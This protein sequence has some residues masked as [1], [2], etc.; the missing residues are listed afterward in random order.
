MD[1]ATFA[2]NFFMALQAKSSA[3]NSFATGGTIGYDP[4]KPTYAGQ[5]QGDNA[6]PD[7]FSKVPQ[8]LGS[9]FPQINQITGGQSLIP[10]AQRLAMST[11]TEKAFYS[12]FLQDEAGVNP[13]DVFDMSKRLAPQISNISTPRFTN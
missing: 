5:G 12:G 9:S 4:S 2:A 11:P 7:I 10:S 1:P 3:M 6:A 8:G 13:D